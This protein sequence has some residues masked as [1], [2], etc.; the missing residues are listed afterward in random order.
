MG[1]LVARVIQQ[2]TNLFI[3]G[4]HDITYAQYLAKRHTYP[5]ASIGII[6][7]DSHFETRVMYNLI[8]V[9]CSDKF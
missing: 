1:H 9:Q 4:G 5:D 8:L 3:G 7:I 6:N 2:I